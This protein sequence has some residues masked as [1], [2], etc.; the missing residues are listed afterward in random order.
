MLF[1]HLTALSTSIVRGHPYK[2]W[3]LPPVVQVWFNTVCPPLW[4]SV[5]DGYKKSCVHYNC[6]AFLSENNGTFVL[7]NEHLYSV[8]QSAKEIRSTNT[9]TVLGLLSAKRYLGLKFSKDWSSSLMP[10]VQVHPG[11]LGNVFF[12]KQVL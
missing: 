6:L 10:S 2:T 12:I 8:V 3:T 9:M 5:V 1:C 7:V 4:M 11:W